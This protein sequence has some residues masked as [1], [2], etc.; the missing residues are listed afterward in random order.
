MGF[1][2]ATGPDLRHAAP[3]GI[4]SRHPRGSGET[5]INPVQSSREQVAGATTA[6]R[7]RMD[8]WV[9]GS[10]RARTTAV[11]AASS[12]SDPPGKM[13]ANSVACAG[14]VVT[15]VC[16]SPIWTAAGVRRLRPFLPRR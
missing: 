15:A 8:V 12:D 5:R 2:A 4:R 9:R 6:G 13:S 16:E 14:S 3:S 1:S 10:A 11:W 7:T